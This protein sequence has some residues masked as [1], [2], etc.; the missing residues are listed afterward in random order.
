MLSVKFRYHGLN[1]KQARRDD[2]PGHEGVRQFAQNGVQGVDGIDHAIHDPGQSGVSQGWFAAQFGLKR[3]QGG[4]CMKRLHG[5]KRD[6]LPVQRDSEGR[7][8]IVQP[9]S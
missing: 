7:V 1:G 5:S 4:K 9:R 3:A 2:G 6:R 8:E